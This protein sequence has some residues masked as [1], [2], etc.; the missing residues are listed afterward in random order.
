[1]IR[2]RKRT[3]HIVGQNQRMGRDETASWCDSSSGVLFRS[4]PYPLGPF[5]SPHSLILPFCILAFS[6]P[7][8][9]TYFHFVNS[10][11]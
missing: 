7:R 6:L 9:L 4:L 2:A 11:V 5:P 8:L 3:P 1:M 10:Y